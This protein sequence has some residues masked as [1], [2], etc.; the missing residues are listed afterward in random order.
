[1]IGFEKAK[2]VLLQ[3]VFINKCLLE[4]VFGK[5]VGHGINPDAD[6][7]KRF[8]QEYDAAFPNPK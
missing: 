3:Y 1:M 8:R 7:Y 2:F 6:G 5:Y 4:Y